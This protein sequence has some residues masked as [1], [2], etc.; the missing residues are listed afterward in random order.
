MVTVIFPDQV[1]LKQKHSSEVTGDYYVYKLLQRNVKGKHVMVF[2]VK[3]L[4]SNSS[5][6]VRTGHETCVFWEHS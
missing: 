3:A 6:Q 5:R 2:R 4:F 1:F